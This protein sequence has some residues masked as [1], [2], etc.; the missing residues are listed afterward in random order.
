MT[1]EFIELFEQSKMT[2]ADFCRAIGMR[3]QRLSNYLRN[4]IQMSQAYYELYK[5][6]YEIHIKS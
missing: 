1:K 4:E 6:N 2:K 3:Q 5:R